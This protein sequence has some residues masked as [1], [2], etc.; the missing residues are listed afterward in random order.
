MNERRKALL[1]RFRLLRDSKFVHTVWK[2]TVYN[3]PCRW[4]LFYRC[5]RENQRFL[6]LLNRTRNLSLNL[7]SP[8]TMRGTGGVVHT[9]PI[10]EVSGP[11]DVRGTG[12]ATR[13][14]RA[15][16]LEQQGEKLMLNGSE[17]FLS[18]CVAI[19]TDGE[20]LS[21]AWSNQSLCL[22]PH[23]L[24][25]CSRWARL[26][27]Q[28]V[29]FLRVVPV[30]EILTEGPGAGELIFSS[31]GAKEFNGVWD[32][33]LSL[34]LRARTLQYHRNSEDDD[35]DMLGYVSL[36]AI[37]SCVNGGERPVGSA[38]RFIIS[39]QMR[40]TEAPWVL[41]VPTAREADE[42]RRLLAPERTKLQSTLT[43]GK[44]VGRKLQ[45]TFKARREERED[46]IVPS[47]STPY[48]VKHQNTLRLPPIT[49]PVEDEES[50]STSVALPEEGQMS[51]LV[52]S[53]FE[54]EDNVVPMAVSELEDPFGDIYESLAPPDTD[55]PTPN[56][57]QYEE[58]EHNGHDEEECFELQ[59]TAEFEGTDVA[60]QLSRILSV[61]DNSSGHE[62]SGHISEAMQSEDLISLSDSLA[63]FLDG[64]DLSRLRRLTKMQS[65]QS[66]EI[67]LEAVHQSARQ[68]GIKPTR[69]AFRLREGL[70]AA[71]DDEEL[72]DYA[73]LSELPPKPFSMPEQN[74]P[75]ARANAQA[76]LQAHKARSIM[77]ADCPVPRR[78]LQEDT[79]KWV[80]A[81]SKSQ[82]LEPVP[83]AVPPK[84]R[85]PLPKRGRSPPPN[86]KS[87]GRTSPRGNINDKVA[88]K[89]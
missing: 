19:S 18:S 71:Q 38:Q 12:I 20:T 72:I 83:P 45:E 89:L 7:A 54:D 26:L 75:V 69:A 9:R 58:P 27:A 41:A 81:K 73:A 47:L 2:F 48:N 4:M 13:R 36:S 28:W 32:E 86:R 50:Y 84:P 40:G 49:A 37:S 14:F 11:C 87:G 52:H 79:K 3:A 42:W 80:A 88:Q 24:A 34:R 1:P 59:A 15:S 85:M 35:D 57:S 56:A 8:R 70:A 74:R 64:G 53:Y 43:F 61:Y 10:I 51:L 63:A 33:D 23:A 21:L 46:V 66:R 65:S 55:A 67:L 68:A 39:L 5:E 77:G 17:Y 78:A 31:I 62:E 82:P 16:L 30:S 44:E 29:S 60:C 25:R 76:L 6:T 22:R